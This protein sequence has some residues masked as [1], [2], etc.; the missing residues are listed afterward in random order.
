MVS[1]ET[2]TFGLVGAVAV[3]VLQVVIEGM[4]EVALLEERNFCI[5]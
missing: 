1:S 4:L 5:L 3:G 2:I